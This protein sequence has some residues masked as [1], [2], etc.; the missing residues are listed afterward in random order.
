MQNA[1]RMQI[2][3]HGGGSIR[4]TGGKRQ[5]ARERERERERAQQN[6]NEQGG[7]AE[8]KVKCKK[9][10]KKERE[11]ERERERDRREGKRQARW[12]AGLHVFGWV[13]VVEGAEVGEEAS[14]HYAFH[15]RIRDPINQAGK[16][17]DAE[18]MRSP[19]TLMRPGQAK[20]WTT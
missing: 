3:F 4:N 19:F 10:R 13:E 18:R 6:K 14:V 16:R 5:R 8:G 15:R 1:K 12:T 9:K 7:Q 2:S 20:R 17:R 11:R